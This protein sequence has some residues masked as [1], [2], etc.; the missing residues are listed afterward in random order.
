MWHIRKINPLEKVIE[1]QFIAFVGAGGKSSLIDYLAKQTSREKKKTVITT[2]TKIYAKEPYELLIHET[3]QNGI[4]S[5]EPVRVGKS[6]ADGKLTAV[7][8]DDILAL[9]KSYDLVFIEADGAKGKPLKYPAPQEPVI[10]PFSDRVFV[11][12]GLDSLSGHIKDKVFRWELL[13]EKVGLTG[14]EIISPELFG[15][16]FIDEILLKGVEKK[17]CTIVLN[18]YDALV[19][20]QSALEIAKVIILQTGVESII[21]ASLVFQIFYEIRRLTP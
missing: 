13:L 6:F 11:V 3:V 5:D 14:D 12:A 20:R 17:I 19:Q 2:T 9:G 10:P 18:K 15:H 16:F 7:T 4:P 1:D 8:F 21:I